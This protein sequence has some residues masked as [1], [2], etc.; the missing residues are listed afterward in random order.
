VTAKLKQM[1]ENKVIPTPAED[2]QTN[3]QG[4]EEA[5]TTVENPISHAEE[6]IDYKT[7][8]SESSREAQ[9]LLDELKAKDAELER[10]RQ[11]E[12]APTYRDDPDFYPGFDQLSED[13]QK[14]LIAYTNS[15]KEKVKQELYSDPA[16]SDARRSYNERKWDAAFDQAATKYPELRDAKD[17]FK[18]KYFRDNNV[19]DNIGS[20][21]EDLSKVYLFD[22]AK[23]LGA[24]EA[25]EM[26]NR[27]DIERAKGGD[28][29][30][31]AS[32]SL[33]DW[34]QLANSNPAQF[35]KLA[36]EYKRDLESGKLK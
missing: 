30:P 31:T 32:R 8:F 28:S 15:I 12:S 2:V 23:D 13:E 21:L 5:E 1:E 25:L 16:I 33:E 20:I 18:T 3:P 19:P 6:M 29:T 10:V 27:I 24:Q 26:A 9:R 11:T 35:A 14:N 22:K 4:T 34:A 7:K 36:E 17:E